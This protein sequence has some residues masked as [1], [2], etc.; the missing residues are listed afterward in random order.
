MR[1]AVN[2]VLR[3]EGW[4]LVRFLHLLG[5]A[6]FVGG[7][8]MLVLVV[9]PALRGQDPALM[10]GAARRFGIVSVAALL[11]IVATGAAMASHFDRWSDAKLHWKI[12][13]LVL[14]FV[15]TGLHTRVPYARAI[16]YAVL[17]ISLVIFW[18]GVALAH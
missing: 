13:L 18:L 5:V 1:Q 10:R 7:Q 12:G 11:V 3:V 14:V 9:T 16:S 2:N 6:L 8:L 17:V 15:L 4:E